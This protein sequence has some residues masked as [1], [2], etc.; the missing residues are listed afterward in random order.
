MKLSFLAALALV[1]AACSSPA[2]KQAAP[3]ASPP[4]AVASPPAPP[5]PKADI[6]DFGLDLSARKPAVQ[7]GDD[8]FEYANGTWYDTYSIPD[9]RSSFGIF[10]RLDEQS[11]NR[12]REI[13]EQAASS[14]PA[15]PLSWRPFSRFRVRH[16]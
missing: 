9:D 10:T 7:P 6:G 8:F 11:Q 12:V 1:L 4:P 15:G 13:I 2:V 16:A 3:A 5:P 14:H